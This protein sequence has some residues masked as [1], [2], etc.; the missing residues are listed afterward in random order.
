MAV[1]MNGWTVIKSAADPRL[2]TI[3][4]PGTKRK[5]TVRRV[6]APVFAAF[7]ADWQKRMPAKYNLNPGPTDGWEYRKSRFNTNWSNH[8]SGTAVDVLYSSVLPADGQP[9]M[10]DQAK[11][12]LDGILAEYVTTDGRR[13]FANGEWWKPPH[14]DGMHTEILQSWDRGAKGKNA[15][16]ADVKNVRD[17]LGIKRNGVRTK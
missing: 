8:A 2:R 13:I 9:H 1:S 4:I 17:R 15:T 14:C 3:R 12:I 11:L 7:F 16:I 10:S 5:I 6:A